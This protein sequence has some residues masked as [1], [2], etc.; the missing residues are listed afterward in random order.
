MILRSLASRSV[1]HERG[2]RAVLV[3]GLEPE[4]RLNGPMVARGPA[5]NEVAD[6]HLLA[7]MVLG[8]PFTSILTVVSMAS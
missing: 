7:V 3:A 2:F 4:Q 6:D 5:G 8:L 1:G